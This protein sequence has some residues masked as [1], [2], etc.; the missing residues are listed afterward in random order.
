MW[1]NMDGQTMLKILAAFVGA[2][3]GGDPVLNL[4]GLCL[5]RAANPLRFADWHVW[6]GTGFA[7]QL[8]TVNQL[9]QYTGQ[10]CTPVNSLFISSMIRHEP[11]GVYIGLYSIANEYWHGVYY[12]LSHDLLHRTEQKMFY[13]T[14]STCANLIEIT[15]PPILG[16]A[17]KSLIL[18]TIGNTAQLFFTL[19][20]LDNCQETIN[21]D[22]LR[23][24]VTI[25]QN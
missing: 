19:T 13:A 11:S 1:L 16:L 2:T 4:A 24:A 6:D 7:L 12:T 15:Y 23:I 10:L 9:Q 8:P 22:S 18:D 21:R 17:S 3:T 5:I 14:D 20:Q 25:T